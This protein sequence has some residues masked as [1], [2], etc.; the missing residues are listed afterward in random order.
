MSTDLFQ[1][2]FPWYQ[3]AVLRMVVVSMKMPE[4]LRELVA[5][6]DLAKDRGEGYFIRE[7]VAEKLAKLGYVVSDEDWKPSSRKGVG[8]FPTHRK[9]ADP[10]TAEA[11]SKWQI[12]ATLAGGVRDLKP[13]EGASSEASLAAESPPAYKVSAGVDSLATKLR[14][15]AVKAVK[16]GKA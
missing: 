6:T 15:V 8:G 3:A 11:E 2:L 12:A 13:V 10:A 7:A 5:K 1:E 16:K 14:K 9:N 4:S